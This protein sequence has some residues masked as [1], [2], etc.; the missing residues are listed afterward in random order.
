[1]G[2]SLKNKACTIISLLYFFNAIVEVVAEAYALDTIIYITKPLIP[3]LLMALYFYTSKNDSK[4]FYV[5]MFFSLLTNL[6]F[7]P[8]TETALFY[9]VIAYTIHR[10][11]LLVLIFRIVRIKN[12]LLFILATIPL[13]FIFF[14]IFTSSDVPQNSYYLIFF[15]N[16]IAAVLGGIAIA[17]YIS[18]DNR[19][20][21]YLLISVLLFLGLQLV[22]YIEK[23]YLVNAI[24]YSLRPLA[25]SLNILAFYVFYKF[26]ILSEKIKLQ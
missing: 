16:L 14:F 23:Y 7:I 9:G 11:F 2:L 8:N 4:L 13:G 24:T 19:Q 26:V 18:N 17:T 5:I 1:M 21:S 10:I 25:M 12:Y 6:L 22:I 3:G 20:N 15:H